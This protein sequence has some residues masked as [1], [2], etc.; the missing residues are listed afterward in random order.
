M[1]NF[2]VYKT[3]SYL[4][5]FIKYPFGGAD[6]DRTRYLLSANQMLSQMSYSPMYITG[7]YPGIFI[8][9]GRE[10]RIRTCDPLIPNQVHY[11]A[12]LFPEILSGALGKNRTRNPQIRSLILY[13]VELLAQA[14]IIYFIFC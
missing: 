4:R 10:N 14:Y 8:S 12:V 11:Q 5:M 3:F 1:L 13:P 2:D 9:N 6:E 7:V